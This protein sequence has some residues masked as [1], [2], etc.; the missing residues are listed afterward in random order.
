MRL[1][2]KKIHEVRDGWLKQHLR[3]FGLTDGCNVGAWVLLVRSCFIFHLRE[4][5][6][7]KQLMRMN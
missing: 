3:I 7:K 1:G 4:A 5:E 6:Q 2:K